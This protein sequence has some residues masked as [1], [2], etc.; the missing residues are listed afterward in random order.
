[1]TANKVYYPAFIGGKILGAQLT[2]QNKGNS[3][4]TAAS[5]NGIYYTFEGRDYQ[6]L[7]LA[8]VTIPA[9]ETITI[10]EEFREYL[11]PNADIKIMVDS[12]GLV[13]CVLYP[14][15]LWGVGDV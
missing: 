1:M 11:K 5:T 2:I 8:G 12:G 14:S 13:D 15:I 6:L 4:I 10:N 9:G 3:D 7:S